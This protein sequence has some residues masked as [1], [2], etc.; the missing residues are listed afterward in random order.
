MACLIS[1]KKLLHLWNRSR[2]IMMKKLLKLFKENCLMINLKIFLKISSLFCFSRAS[3]I[4]LRPISVTWRTKFSVSL[5]YYWLE[6][7][8]RSSKFKNNNKNKSRDNV[9]LCEE[10]NSNNNEK[11]KETRWWPK[12][13]RCNNFEDKYIKWVKAATQWSNH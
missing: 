8:K 4:K 5:L 11:K 7:I 2:L 9:K 12:W 10:K 6:W 1:S 3:M 13:T